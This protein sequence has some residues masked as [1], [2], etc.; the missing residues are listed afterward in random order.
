MRTRRWIDWE[1]IAGPA[2]AA[3]PVWKKTPARSEIVTSL[4]GFAPLV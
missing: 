3:N 2:A 1:E 4:R